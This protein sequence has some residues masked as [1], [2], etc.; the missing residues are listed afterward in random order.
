VSVILTLKNDTVGGINKILLDSLQAKN[1]EYRLVNA[2][3][4]VYDTINYPD[5]FLNS[6][7]PPGFPRHLLTLKISTP[8]M[9]LINLNPPK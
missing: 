4:E 3:L 1:M 8:I 2:V 6:L 7:N 5:E 9:L